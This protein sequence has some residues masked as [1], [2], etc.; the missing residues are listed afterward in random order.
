[1]HAED[2][3]SRVI[4]GHRPKNKSLEGSVEARPSLGWIV[5]DNDTSLGWIVM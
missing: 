4:P 5:M 2:A 3:L 1:M